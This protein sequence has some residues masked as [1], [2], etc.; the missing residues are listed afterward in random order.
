MVTSALLSLLGLTAAAA[1]FASPLQ[2]RILAP[3]DVV[4]LNHDGSSQI[5]K[6]ADYEALETAAA[7]PAPV[8]A[9][10]PLHNVTSAPAIVRRD[11]DKSEEVQ[12][13]S[14]ETFI[15]WDVAISPLVS[16]AGQ[17]MA[18][19][20]ISEG[21][22]LTDHV[23]IGGRITLGGPKVIRVSLRKKLDMSWS[24]TQTNRFRYGL[25]PNMYGIVVSQ[26]Y[27]RRIQ[28]NLLSGCPD[29]PASTP[30]EANTYESQ[31]YG[32]LAWVKGVIRLCSNETY[33][34]PYCIGEGQ[35]R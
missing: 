29:S 9:P 20:S 17:T 8:S 13:M 10:A 18:Y 3:D 33:P 1:V 16:S 19:V 21:Y 24:T 23:R 27:V 22:K 15:D 12:V 32:N 4:L 35:H 5:M 2:S 31:S 26:P 14:N 11:C 25:P 34:I 30:F 6:A 7:A 28:G